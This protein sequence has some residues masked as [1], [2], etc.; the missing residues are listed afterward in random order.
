MTTTPRVR[1]APSP[2]GTVHL[3][4][5]RSAL[6]NWG[7]AR[8]RGGRF[9]LRMEDTDK[10]RSTKESE[11]AILEGLRWL[12]IDW[13]EGPDCGGPFAPY[14]QSERIGRHK[15]RVEQLMASGD[16]FRCFHTA[17]ELD[18][19]RAALGEHGGP[20]RSDFRDLERQESDRRAAAGE[21][22]TTRFRVPQGRTA[23]TDAVRGEVDFDNAEVEDWVMLRQDGTPTYKPGRSV[24]R[25]RHADQPRVAR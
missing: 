24:R 5:A 11:R 18:H 1:I 9:V 22:F 8:G 16:A 2:T 4:L 19:K 6:F 21:A 12:G 7:Y 25:H 10:E 15:A 14:Y 20:L 3:G 17:Q 13:D 23:F